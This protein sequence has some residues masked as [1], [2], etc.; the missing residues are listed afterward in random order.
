MRN[1]KFYFVNKDSAYSSYQK[2]ISMAA[3]L[4]S[5]ESRWSTLECTTMYFF[6]EKDAAS[7]RFCNVS[8]KH[9]VF[10]SCNHPAYRS[11]FRSGCESPVTRIVD[12][13]FPGMAKFIGNNERDRRMLTALLTPI[14]KLPPSL[15]VEVPSVPQILSDDEVKQRLSRHNKWKARFTE[16]PQKQPPKFIEFLPPSMKEKKE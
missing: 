13:D 2:R 7:V 15:V 6:I 5:S 1:I 11:N 8:H 4:A 12:A 14:S 3:M 16:Q 9:W 10:L